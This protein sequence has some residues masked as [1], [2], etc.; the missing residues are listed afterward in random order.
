MMQWLRLRPSTAGG[1]S[2]IL[3]RELRSHLPCKVPKKNFF[4]K[5]KGQRTLLA[6]A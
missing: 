4:I 1:K 2:S 3:V 6:Y 5:G